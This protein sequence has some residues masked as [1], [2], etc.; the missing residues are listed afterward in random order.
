MP[1]PSLPSSGCRQGFRSRGWQGDRRDEDLHGRSGDP[2]VDRNARTRPDGRQAA[3][4]R[5]KEDGSEEAGSGRESLQGGAGE[6]SGAQ[7]KVRPVGRRAARGARQETE[8]RYRNK[9]PKQTAQSPRPL[10]ELTVRT[11][12]LARMLAVTLFAVAPALGR[13]R[14]WR[15]VHS[16][17]C[18]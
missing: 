1:I 9:K 7:G 13:E 17:R 12:Y 8:I 3:S 5:R 2:G 6:D 10:I 18:L 4:R 14:R 15:R 11:R 16:R